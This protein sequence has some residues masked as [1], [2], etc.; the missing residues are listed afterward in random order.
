MAGKK[1]GKK[2]ARCPPLTPLPSQA[3]RPR[4]L[5]QLRKDKSEEPQET[6][7]LPTSDVELTDKHSLEI[8]K[9]VIT[10]TVRSIIEQL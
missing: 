1:K 2:P 5:T 9:T 10:A 7:Q 6:V 8:V 3:V 4:E